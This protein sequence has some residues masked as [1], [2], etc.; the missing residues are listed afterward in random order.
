MFDKQIRPIL[1]YACQVCFI[2]KQDY[3]IEKV[4]LVYLKF[5]LNSIPSSCT[6]FV[7]AECGRFP[8][9]IKHKIQVLKY[10]KRLLESGV[11]KTIR[12][13]YNML[14]E[15]FITGVPLSKIFLHK[16]IILEFGMNNPFQMHRLQK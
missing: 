13:A 4:H 6:P 2:G 8:L 5:L 10:W 3:D 1:D 7:Y 15:L 11:S 9:A 16:L 12:H 14:F